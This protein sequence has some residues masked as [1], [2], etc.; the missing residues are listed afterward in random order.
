MKREARTLEQ[1]RTLGMEAVLRELGPVDM[2]DFFNSSIKATG[3]A[4][5]SAISGSTG[6]RLTRSQNR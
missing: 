3:T 2:V 5:K 4:P 1:I 6:S